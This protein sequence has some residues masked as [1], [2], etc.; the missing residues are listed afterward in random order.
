M[1]SLSCGHSVRPRRRDGYISAACASELGDLIERDGDGFVYTDPAV[2]EAE[3][4]RIWY[5]TWVYVG[6]QRGARHASPERIGPS[7]VWS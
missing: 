3:L 4:E 2:F 7:R 5:R 1:P 6:R